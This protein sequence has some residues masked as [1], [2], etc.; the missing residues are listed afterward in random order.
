MPNAVH[1][2]G[3]TAMNLASPAA[4]MPKLSSSE[5]II[6]GGGHEVFCKYLQEL[7]KASDGL[8]K[9]LVFE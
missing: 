4:V 8:G 5:M 9:S 6:F 3:V 1:P 2:L 7:M